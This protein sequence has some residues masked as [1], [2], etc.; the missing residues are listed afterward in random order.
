MLLEGSA[1]ALLVFG[2]AL[3]LEAYLHTD[4]GG[5]VET[6]CLACRWQMGTTGTTPDAPSLEPCAPRVEPV[7][8]GPESRTA[9]GEVRVTPARGPPSPLESLAR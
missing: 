9:D 8:A 3:V 5:A 6:H 7:V 4:D 2:S 1:V